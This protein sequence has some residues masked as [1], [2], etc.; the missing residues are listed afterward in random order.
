MIV[1]A[2]YRMSQE[3]TTLV[4]RKMRSCRQ[5]WRLSLLHSDASRHLHKLHGELRRP[6]AKECIE[7][8]YKYA[9]QVGTCVYRVQVAFSFASFSSLAVTIWDYSRTSGLLSLGMLVVTNKAGAQLSC[10]L[11]HIAS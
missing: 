8:C 10:V 11:A 3:Q 1:P 9:M 2:M 7:R 6:G 5:S 4:T